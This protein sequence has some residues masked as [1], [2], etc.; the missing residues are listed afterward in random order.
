MQVQNSWLLFLPSNPQPFRMQPWQA[1]ASFLKKTPLR[2]T[3]STSTASHRRLPVTADLPTHKG[4]TTSVPSKRPSQPRR[5]QPFRLDPPSFWSPDPI[6]IPPTHGQNLRC[7]HNPADP[8][9]P[10]CVCSLILIIAPHV[11]PLSALS[12]PSPIRVGVSRSQCCLQHPRFGLVE[13]NHT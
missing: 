1:P 13:S 11:K 10:D 6:P 2:S 12:S 8:T 9:S 3:S 7:H 5:Q 4:H